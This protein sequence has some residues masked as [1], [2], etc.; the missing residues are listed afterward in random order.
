MT[1]EPDP[2]RIPLSRIPVMSSRKLVKTIEK[3]GAVRETNVGLTRGSH[4]AY[5]REA[6]GRTH[7]SVV[8]LGKRELP[9]P[10]VRAV[11]RNLE[12]CIDDFLAE[13]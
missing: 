4:A 8:I 12:I 1:N 10:T 6:N 9:K 11:L 5:L 2:S 3:L 13:Y 7:I